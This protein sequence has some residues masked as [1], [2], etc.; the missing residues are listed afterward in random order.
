[1]PNGQRCHF[2]HEVFFDSQNMPNGQRCHFLHEVFFDS[3]N[4]KMQREEEEEALSQL[5]LGQCSICE[6]A[7][8][9]CGPLV[10][11]LPKLSLLGV[12]E[13]LHGTD[14]ALQAALGALIALTPH[15]R[16]LTIDADSEGGGAEQWAEAADGQCLSCG[17]PPAVTALRH[18]QMLQVCNARL[19]S[20]PGGPYLAG[21]TLL[22]LGGNELR[23]ALPPAVSA[24]T[25]LQCLDVRS[26][27][28][29]YL[30]P[31]SVDM[32]AQLASLS[33]IC[34]DDTRESHASLCNLQVTSAAAATAAVMPK[35]W[36][37]LESN[38]EVLDE[39]SAKLGVDL[40]A[41]NLH[42]CDV[43]S[44][45]EEL[46]EMVPRPVKAVLLLFPVTD[47]TEKARAEEQC[48]IEARGQHV[49][50]SLFYMKQSIGNACGTIGLLHSLA[51]NRGALKIA[52]GSF[53]A[54]FLKA[55]EG[56]DAAARGAFLEQPPEGGPNIDSIHEAAARQGA[57]EAPPAD[58]EVNLHF[59][60]FVCSE[61]A[62]YELDGRKRGPIN[63]GACD[64]GRLLEE[65]AKVVRRNFMDRGGD[66][67]QFTLVALAAPGE[68]WD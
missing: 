52:D 46:L 32:L 66:S 36:I 23:G 38:P 6:H 47:E 27:P 5:T 65:T 20:L 35:K 26:N 17:L 45:D 10:A 19:P 21:I 48:E 68:E 62:L 4:V 51:N 58:E 9:G 1:M 31:A 60:A 59:A 22:K 28:G 42:F 64:P 43:F 57:T 53:L 30:T 2:L 15:V 40:G 12:M 24:A 34:L 13:T 56:M 25:A 61:G 3:Q 54:Q 63:H 11:E 41:S 18:L 33:S 37:P 50:P 7:F 14:A 67:V 16:H 8:G 29:L 44:L 39:Y 49:S 55:T